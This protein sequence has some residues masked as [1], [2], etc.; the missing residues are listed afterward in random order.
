MMWPASVLALWTAQQNGILTLGVGDPGAGARPGLTER[1]T[2]PSRGG[3]YTGACIT[4]APSGAANLPASARWIHDAAGT[5]GNEGG[6]M[7]DTHDHDDAI[8]AR[9]AFLK[10]ARRLRLG[11]G[12]P[13]PRAAGTVSHDPNDLAR[14]YSPEELR[15]TQEHF[16]RHVPKGMY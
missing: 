3:R 11:T 6:S 4:S 14:P 16:M 7:S 9:P 13:K 8:A 1:A 12:R 10:S 15:H 5:A 2:N